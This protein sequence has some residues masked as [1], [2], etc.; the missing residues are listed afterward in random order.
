MDLIEALDNSGFNDWEWTFGEFTRYLEPVASQILISK[1]LS[2]TRVALVENG[3]VTDFI[4][5]SRNQKGYVGSIFRGKVSRVLP[6]MQAAFVDIGLDRAAFLYAG[7]VRDEKEGP[8]TLDFSTADVEE[9]SAILGAKKQ[10]QEPITPIQDL[11]REG[12]EIIV[13]VAKDPLGTKGA[14][15]TTHITFPGRFVVF[16]PTV[17]HLGISRRIEDQDERARL[18][19]II[20]NIQIPNGGLIVRTAAEGASEDALRADI[21][22][23]SKLNETVSNTY[24]QSKKIGLIHTELDIEFRSVR[25][26]IHDGVERVI[27]DDKS[28]K[29]EIEK[30]IQKF[31]PR[32]KGQVAFYDE[33]VSLFDKYEVDLAVSRSLGRKVWLKSGGY[34][35]FDEAEALVV[36]DI[37]TG[38]YVGKKDFEETILK[39]NLEA[40]KEICSQLRIRNCG[41]IIII[42]FID[43]SKPGNKEAV[44]NALNEE[45]KKDR[46]KT[47]V[48]GMSDLGLVQMTRKRVRPSLVKSLCEPCSYCDGKGYIKSK[49]YIS[50]E[51]LREVERETVRTL[52]GSVIVHCHPDVAAWIYDEEPRLL[53]ALEQESCRRIILK[54]END[55]HIEQFDLYSDEDI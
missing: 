47:N 19:S 15:I 27:V 22:Y 45:L 46:A 17:A 40:V 28:S 12:Q 4:T 53:E 14:R 6:G 31:L 50:H 55:Y 54:V 11:L 44:E 48:L 7:D 25:D 43:M 26:F 21:Q 16:M 23:L 1:N 41:G 36:I 51:I 24:S 42:D 32:F 8:V 33:K 38:S 37:N 2:E 18:K 29:E 35:V 13:Q 10:T 34:I 52:E 9:D 5:E 3:E 30:F 20:A 49:G 39:T